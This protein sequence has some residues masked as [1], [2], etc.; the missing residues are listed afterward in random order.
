MT[1]AIVATVIAASAALPAPSVPT[2]SL[3]DRR[4]AMALSIGLLDRDEFARLATRALRRE[5]GEDGDVAMVALQ[6]DP[7]TI[8]D[9]EAGIRM[10]ARLTV[11]YRDS[12]SLRIEVT[13]TAAADATG[14]DRLLAVMVD[15]LRHR[16]ALA[17]TTAPD[18]WTIAGRQ[19]AINRVTDARMVAGASRNAA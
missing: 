17:R 6:A 1:L 7:S 9:Y 4:A 15:R 5:I 8:R 2:P 18:D 14:R 13:A 16:A 12:S 3:D 10:N 19:D 11:V